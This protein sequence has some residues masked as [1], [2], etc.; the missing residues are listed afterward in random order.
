MKSPEQ[1]EAQA[2]TYVNTDFS[3]NEELHEFIIAGI[4]FK[5]G[6]NWI[7][8]EEVLPLQKEVEELNAIIKSYEK[9]LIK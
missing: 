3:S 8:T 4:A 7:Q 6:A 5:A 1:I 9:L 2:E